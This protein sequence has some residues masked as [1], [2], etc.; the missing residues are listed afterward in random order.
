MN[1]MQKGPQPLTFKSKIKK[2]EYSVNEDGS[3][4]ITETVENKMLWGAR[5][6]LSFYREHKKSID[7][8]DLQLD[9]KH[10]KMLLDN[11]KDILTRMKDIEPFIKVS[12]ERVIALNKKQELENKIK[13]VNNILSQ[14]IKTR[15]VAFLG[16]LMQNMKEGEYKDIKNGLEKESYRAEFT[17]MMQDIRKKQARS[18]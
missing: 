9:A 3:V 13:A 4:N 17:K 14:P 18:K 8:I 1:E 7:N 5:D 16:G 2:T 11:K 6:F 12:E 10:K 15:N